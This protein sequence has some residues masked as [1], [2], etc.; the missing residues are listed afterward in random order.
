MCGNTCCMVNAAST[1]L[2]DSVQ[3]VDVEAIG[4]VGEVRGDRDRKPLGMRG[5]RRC[6]REPGQLA[7]ALDHLGVGGENVRGLAVQAEADD[8]SRVRDARSIRS[9]AAA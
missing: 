8:V 9:R 6:R 5:R 4:F 3:Q 7:L 1:A 2:R